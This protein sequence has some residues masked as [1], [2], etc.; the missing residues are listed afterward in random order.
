MLQFVTTQRGRL[1][2]TRRWSGKKPFSP[3]KTKRGWKTPHSLQGCAQKR[4]RWRCL[5][6][7]SQH[8]VHRRQCSLFNFRRLNGCRERTVRTNAYRKKD[9]LLPAIVRKAQ[10]VYGVLWYADHNYHFP[11]VFKN[12]IGFALIL[13]GYLRSINGRTERR[14]LAQICVE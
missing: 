5:A 7:S 10:H 14:P 3:S 8:P 6:P 13:K 11:F 9:F 4:S 1:R 12:C 2:P